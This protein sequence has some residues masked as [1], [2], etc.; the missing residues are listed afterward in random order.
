[1]LI[2]AFVFNGY[3]GMLQ[4]LRDFVNRFVHTIGTGCDKA[5]NLS[6]AI[7]GVHKGCI[8]AGAYIRR[9]NIR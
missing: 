6:S 4:A 2:E 3:K 1:M 9:R 7:V 8:A 5:F